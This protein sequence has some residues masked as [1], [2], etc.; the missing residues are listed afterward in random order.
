MQI[1]NQGDNKLLMTATS[2]YT[3]PGADR[4]MHFFK[5][6]F[7]FSGTLSGQ[8]VVAQCNN[9][10]VLMDGKQVPP[11]GLPFQLYLAV[12]PDYRSMQ[13]QLANVMGVT[14]PIYLQRQQ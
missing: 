12:A 1:T 4:K 3:V 13:G 9:G 11:Q 8:N 2:S 5:E 7:L 10:T 14:A 6:K